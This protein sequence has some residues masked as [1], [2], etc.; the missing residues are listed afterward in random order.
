MLQLDYKNKI[1]MIITDVDGVLT[2]GG[3]YVSTQNTEQVKKLNFK[4]LMGM[5]LA[6]KN[7]YR[8][9]IISGEKNQ[10]IDGIAVRFGIED[11]HQ[12]IRVKLPVFQSILEKYSLSPEEVCYIGDDVNDLEVLKFVKTAI[13][14]PDANFKVK[15][16]EN[17]IISSFCGGQGAFRE[18]VDSLIY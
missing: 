18:V 6:I 7:G 9:G 15:E 5:S 1:K 12:G 2:D 3:V 14:V 17:I 4:D 11:V 13:T 10:I 16:I 8:I